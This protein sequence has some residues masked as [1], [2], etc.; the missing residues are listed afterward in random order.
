MKILLSC[1]DI[2]PYKGSE[3]SVGWNFSLSLAKKYEVFVLA[4]LFC[5]KDI[6]KYIEANDISD[7]LHFYYLETDFNWSVIKF[8]PPLLYHYINKWEKKAFDLAE[9]LNEKYD[10]DVIHKLTLTGFRSPGYLYEI[11]KPFVWGPIGGFQISPWCLLPS[12]GL[13][14]MLFYGI[15]NLLN[16]KDILL[17]NNVRRCVRKANVI[18]SATQDGQKSI[19]KYWHKSSVLIPEVGFVPG[20]KRHVSDKGIFKIGWSSVFYPRK[21]LNLLI[22]AVAASKHKDDIEINVVGGGNLKLEKEWKRKAETLGVNCI[23]HGLKTR[24]ESISIIS[25]CHLFC[26]TSVADMTSTVLLEALSASLPVIVPDEFGFSNI[27]TDSC[28]IK[29]KVK[30]KK[31]FI[32]DYSE[33]IDKLFEDRNLLSSLSNGAYIRAKEFTWD[34]KV[35]ELEKIYW[36][37]IENR[38]P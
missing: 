7:N 2:R 33:A 15:R 27:V 29:I 13:K 22:E 25:A 3:A 21:A 31:Q 16:Y 10:F 32:Y 23:W 1:F 26:I 5:K 30:T 6:D 4:N 12:L 8:W 19:K 38:L 24:N 37:L 34:K 17:N 14:Y 9:R 36:D 18:I 35:Q 28:G 20:F 11:E